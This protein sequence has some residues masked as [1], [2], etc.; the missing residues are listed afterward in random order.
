MSLDDY[1]TRLA[2][3]RAAERARVDAVMAMGNV[4]DMAGVKDVQIINA[5]ARG[6]IVIPA[7]DPITGAAIEAGYQGLRPVVRGDAVDRMRGAAERRKSTLAL[8]SSQ[9]AIGRTYGSLVECYESMNAMRSS[10]VDRVSSGSGDGGGFLEARLD[11][12][13]RI[14]ALEK[15]VGLRTPASA[16]R[17]VRP[18]N[19]G[20]TH[21]TVYALDLVR[22]VFV[23]DMTASQYLDKIKWPKGQNVS[24]LISSLAKALDD[25]MGP[26]WCLEK[27]CVHYG[28]LPTMDHWFKNHLD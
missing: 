8:T 2:S 15:R 19:R 16:L 23:H 25:M 22:A 5:P 4:P 21:T 3:V 7:R 17:K 9:I 28:E 14:N 27:F 24:K 12:K 1:I 26:M 11:L 20:G 18:S 13:A 6:A 10:T